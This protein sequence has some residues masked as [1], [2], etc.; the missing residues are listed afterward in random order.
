MLSGE[1]MPYLLIG[2]VAACFIDFSNI[3][4][5]AVIGTALAL[6]TYYRDKKE[7]EQQARINVNI[8][9]DF[10]DGI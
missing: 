10:E 7:A 6:I 2:F 5:V 4:P 9:E 1:Y 8:E 3:L